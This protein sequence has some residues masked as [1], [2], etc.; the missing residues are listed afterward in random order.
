MV[1]LIHK[2]YFRFIA[3]N[4][5]FFFRIG[6]VYMFLVWD[7][8]DEER[9]GVGAFGEDNITFHLNEGLCLKHIESLCVCLCPFVPI[10]WGLRRPK[11]RVLS[12]ENSPIAPCSLLD[13]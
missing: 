13:T 9:E 2:E 11:K 5:A 6:V 3:S 8:S 10:S 7:G 12:S 4:V 1:F